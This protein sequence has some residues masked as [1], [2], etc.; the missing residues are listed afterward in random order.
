M[1]L[2]ELNNLLDQVGELRVFLPDGNKVPDHFHVTELGLTTKHFI[3]CGN[4]IRTEYYASFQIWVANDTDHRL[5][6]M[7]MKRIISAGLRL[8]KGMDPSV[9]VE[10]QME[11]IGRFGLEFKNGALHLKAKQTDCLAKDACGTGTTKQK[12]ALAELSGRKEKDCAPG[13]GCC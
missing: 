7:K 11:T 8:M 2:S 10:Y 1:K 4:T 3:D 9:E 6:P 5:S 12:V 13:S